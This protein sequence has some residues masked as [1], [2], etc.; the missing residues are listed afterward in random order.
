M[1]YAT[2]A[3]M[4]MRFGQTELV[5]LTDEINRPPTTIDAARVQVALD[6]AR[7]EIDSAVGRIYRL[8]LAGCTRPPDPPATEPTVVPPPQ[9]TRLAC[10]IARYFLFDDAAPEHEV[11]RRYNQARATLDDIA[12]GALQLACPWGGSPGEL[13]AADAQSGSAEVFSEFAPRQIT[14]DALRGF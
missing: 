3:D 14:D 8:P 4:V 11:V 7:M 9:L 12:S 2:L 6:D 5:Q 1:D 13:I 10:D